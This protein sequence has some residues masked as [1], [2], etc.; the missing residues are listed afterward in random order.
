[1]EVMVLSTSITT[2]GSGGASFIEV[3]KPSR[4]QND[5]TEVSGDQL[6]M[7]VPHTIR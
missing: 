3:R 4:R 5:F 2:G 6:G 1:M 7:L